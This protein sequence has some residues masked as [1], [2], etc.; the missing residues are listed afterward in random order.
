MCQSYE[1][2]RAGIVAGEDYAVIKG[3]AAAKTNKPKTD[4]PFSTSSFSY[5]KDAWEHGWYC[6]HE[7]I[8]PAAL[9][10]NYWAKGDYEKAHH[11]SF[12][13]EATGKLSQELEQIVKSYAG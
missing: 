10:R 6:W 1:N 7:R 5:E 13:F 8:L 9:Q 4:N 12:L 11:E 2:K 3:F